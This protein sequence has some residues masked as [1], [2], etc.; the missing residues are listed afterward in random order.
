MLGILVIMFAP[1]FGPVTLVAVGALFASVLIGTSWYFYAQHRLLID[2]T[3]PLLSTTT[4]Y[5]TLIFSS[6]V[7][8]QAQ[9][10]QIRVRFRAV[11]VA[12]A[13]RAT[14]AV[15]GKAGARRRGARADHHVLRRA[16]L[17][18]HLGNLQARSAGSHRADEPLP[19]AADQ[20]DPGAQ[21]LYRQIHGRRHHGVLERAARRQRASAQCL[22]GG[23]R[24]AGKDRRAQQVSAK[25]RRKR[26]VSLSF[27][28]T[29]ASG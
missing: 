23:D 8:E 7:R 2:F 29:S 9:R 26:A 14:G 25:R 19:D 22:R 5:L 18:H 24:Y 12:G 28:S 15:A 10:K 16:R 27:R 13:G 17:H 3:Y 6:F 21:G 4:I 20:R 11:H 1:M